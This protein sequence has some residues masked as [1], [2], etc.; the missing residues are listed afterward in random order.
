MN[1]SSRLFMASA[2]IVAV[3]TSII[4]AGTAERF[5]F[6]RNLHTPGALAWRAL[7]AEF[8]YHPGEWLR[9]FLPTLAIDSCCI[10]SS[11]HASVLGNVCG[12]SSHLCEIRV[13]GLSLGFGQGLAWRVKPREG[14]YTPGK[15]RLQPTTQLPGLGVGSDRARPRARRAGQ[16]RS[17][18]AR[19][20]FPW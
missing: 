18:R 3:P 14:L 17:P 6:R 7:P 5:T 15:I 10:L 4:L 20:C 2:L 9:G 8:T 11:A 16:T 13:I 19:S 12:D 1:W